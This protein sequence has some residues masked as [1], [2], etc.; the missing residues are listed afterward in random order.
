MQRSKAFTLIELLVVIAIIAILAAILFPVFAQAKVAAKKSADLSNLK[1]IGLAG[2]MYAGDYDDIYNPVGVNTDSCAGQ[3]WPGAGGWDV[4]QALVRPYTKNDQIFIS[5]GAKAW[6]NIWGTDWYCKSHLGGM[7]IEDKFYVSYVQNNFDTWSWGAGTTWTGGEHYGFKYT[8]DANISQTSVEDIAG[9]IRLIDGIY[10][11]ISW[12]PYTDYAAYSGIGGNPTYIG[13]DWSATT[14]D[15]GGFFSGR[16]N[17]AWAD[18]HASNL[19]WGQTRPHMWSIQD[20]K[21]QW[22]NTGIK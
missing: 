7:V 12:E 9:T 21:D 10:T 20:D 4:W 19:K 14:A 13:K 8:S 17:V 18:G 1:Q 11:E 3:A 22:I 5:P 15:R 16:V 2:L 6:N